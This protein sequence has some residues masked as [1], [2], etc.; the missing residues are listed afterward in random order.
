MK[1]EP[2]GRS[3]AAVSEYTKVYGPSGTDLIKENQELAREVHRLTTQL[4]KIQSSV[5]QLVDDIF[6]IRRVS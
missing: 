6:S 3:A 1:K 2:I 4:A 5:G